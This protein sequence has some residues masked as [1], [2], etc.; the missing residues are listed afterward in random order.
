MANLPELSQFDSVYQIEVTDPVQGGASGVTNTPLKNLAN[1]TK[2]LKDRVDQG[3]RTNGTLL[4]EYATDKTLELEHIGKHL[5]ISYTGIGGNTLTIPTAGVSNGQLLSVEGAGAALSTLGGVAGVATLIPGMQIVIRFNGTAWEIFGTND[6]GSVVAYA[7]NIAPVGYLK[8]NGAAVSRTVYARLF[9]IIGTTFGVGNGSTTFNLPDLRGEFI[10]GWA[11]DRSVDTGRA[12]GSAQQGSIM[13]IDSTG[14]NQIY[15]A[16][17]TSVSVA[18]NAAL[19][20]Q[21]TGLDFDPNGATN[22][23]NTTSAYAN[24]DG[25]GGF[26]YGVVRPR[27]VALLYCIKF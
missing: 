4:Y 9:A 26:D 23:P 21:R 1:R 14:V 7:R 3:L 12:F 5:Q 18:A 17:M 6:I 22:Y 16:V 27:N 8:C 11:D 20:A 19:V 2:W 24:G 15:S 25:S 10:R 13:A